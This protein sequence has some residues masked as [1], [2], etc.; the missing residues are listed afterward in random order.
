LQQTFNS[1]FGY[2]F[3]TNMPDYI[4]ADRATGLNIRLPSIAP[5]RA[6]IGA[7][8]M[9]DDARPQPAHKEVARAAGG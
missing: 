7:G 9:Q 6:R 5:D 4:L 2:H 1:P 8:I 3:G